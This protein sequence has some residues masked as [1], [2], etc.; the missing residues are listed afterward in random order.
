[1]IN[2]IFPNNTSKD[3]PKGITGFEIASSIS[4]SLA[5]E[6][7][8]IEING[9]LEDLSLPIHSNANVRI[10][11][12]KDPECLEIIRHDAAHIIAEAAKEL[13]P[14]L[15]VTIGPAIKDG[16]Y[17]DFAKKEPFT[18]ADLEKI[19]AKMHHIVKQNNKFIRAVLDRDTAIEMFKEMGEHYK[20]EIISAIPKGE[21]ITLYRQEIGRASCR[22]RV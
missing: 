22:E 8:V 15:Q 1:M 7:M 4:P 21:P 20:A 11:T 12:S 17:Y 19:E 14:D 10:L 18:T 3:F 16:F 6:A 2:I 9:K 5:K 13:F